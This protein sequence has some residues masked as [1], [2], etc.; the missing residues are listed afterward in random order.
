MIDITNLALKLDHYFD[1]NELMLK[2]KIQLSDTEIT[3]VKN[4][5]IEL[6]TNEHYIFSL[7]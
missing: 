7:S 1:I 6:K 4:K 3:Q 2:E 5:Y